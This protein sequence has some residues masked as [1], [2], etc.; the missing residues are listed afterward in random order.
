MGNI[1]ETVSDIV[2]DILNNTDNI[3]VNMMD[4][5]N[6]A[7]YT[8]E[9]LVNVAVYSIIL[10]KSVNY[11]IRDL[12]KLGFGAILHDFAKIVAI[13]DVYEAVPIVRDSLYMKLSA[14]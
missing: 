7:D 8:Y 2:D 5:K 13:T 9:H 14:I 11:N 4:I 12:N 10:G 1:K 3:I 6:F